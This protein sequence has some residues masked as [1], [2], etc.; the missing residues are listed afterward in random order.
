MHWYQSQFLS[1]KKENQTHT[2]AKQQIVLILMED[3]GYVM[4][5]EQDYNVQDKISKQRLD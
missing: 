1:H 5:E 2:H 3:P 4:E